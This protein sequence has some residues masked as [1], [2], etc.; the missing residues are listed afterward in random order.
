VFLC[1]CDADRLLAQETYL[2]MPQ[3]FAGGNSSP[4]IHPEI[5]VSIFL[6]SIVL[7]MRCYV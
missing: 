3:S 7:R 2:G 1:S 6:E 5:A 4:T